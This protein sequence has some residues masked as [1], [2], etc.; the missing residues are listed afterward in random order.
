MLSDVPRVGGELLP[1]HELH[2]S[3]HPP[4]IEFFRKPV[5]KGDKQVVV[6]VPGFQDFDWL[7]SGVTRV[8]DPEVLSS[9]PDPGGVSWPRE[10]SAL[11]Y[12]PGTIEHL[13]HPVLVEGQYSHGLY[14]YIYLHWADLRHEVLQAGAQDLGVDGDLTLVVSVAGQASWIACPNL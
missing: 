3:G 1:G 14:F 4:L 12:G 7:G 11:L 13:A 6:G 9:L 10:L 2:V 5:A 8:E